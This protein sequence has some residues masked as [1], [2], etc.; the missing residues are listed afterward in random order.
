MTLLFSEWLNI[1]IP[2]ESIIINFRTGETIPLLI[3]PIFLL[4]TFSVVQKKFRLKSKYLL[5]FI[6]FVFFII[7]FLP[8]YLEPVEFKIQYLRSIDLNGPTLGYIIFSWFKGFHT[9]VYLIISWIY[10]SRFERNNSIALKKYLNLNL[11]NWLILFQFLGLILIY[12]MVTI[13][14]L[15]PSLSIGADDIASIYTTSSYFMFAFILVL[16]PHSLLPED[17]LIIKRNKYKKSSLSK[18]EKALILKNLLD[19]LRKEKFYLNPNLT[20]SQLAELLNINI[21][22]LSQVINELLDKNFHQLINEYRVN[23]VK[24]YINDPK[25]TLYGIALDSGFNSKSAF[26]RIFKEIT[27][28]T[29]SQY[30][31]S[32]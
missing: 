29:P 22:V 15:E 2:I 13:D 1:L 24:H 17:E 28:L 32:H 4:Y 27:G 5:H 3:G 31:K 18:S 11:I 7:L 6:P 9:T 25:R 19:G 8:F 10:I 14:I 30:K 26:N 20:L 12:T 23:E 16:Y 21:N